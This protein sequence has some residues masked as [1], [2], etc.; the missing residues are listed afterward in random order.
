M[1]DILLINPPLVDYDE[2]N[3]PKVFVNTSF[4]PPINLAYLSSYLEK[5]NFSSVIVD[6]DAEKFGI[7]KIPN[8]LQKY[9]PRVIGIGITSDLIYP[10]S[11]KLIKKVK[12][13]VNTPIVVGG[14][15]PTNSP[16]SLI[17]KSEINYLIRGEGENTLHELMKYLIFNQGELELIN[18][19]SHK[20]NGSVINNPPREL[21]KDL[22]TIPFPSWE[23]FNIKKYFISISYKNPSF[24]ITASR[25]CP[26]R[27][28]FCSTSVFQYYRIRSPKNV[29]DEIE[30]LMKNF[31]IKD[32]TFH[33]PTFNT[34]QD[35]VISFCKEI[36]R[37]KVQLKW[38][39]LCR[40]DNIN[41]IM[42]AYMKAAGCYNIAFGIESSQDIFL[43]FLKKDFSIAQVKKA[44]KIVKKYKIEILTYFMYGIPGQKIED[45][46]HNIKFLK[47]ISP[48]Y[49]NILI[50]NPVSGTELH[51]YA[52][53]KGYLSNFNIETFNSPERLGIQKQWWSIPHLNEEILKH[54][55]IKSYIKY[56]VNIKT[57]LKHLKRYLK[58][59]TRLLYALKNSIIRFF[60]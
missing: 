5:H 15:F 45:L 21:I 52:L 54:F 13:M 44:I 35:W 36:L 8:I 20:T 47:D 29:V 28:T 32:I 59:P 49:I 48:D 60:K 26:Y 7:S 33:D 24:A 12:E 1:V 10:V 18:G 25:G 50:L 17:Q 37:R 6:M 4:F 14:V 30:Y 27:C 43:D 46:E 3:K 23:K 57:I 39:C 11:Y 42:I 55:I 41:D 40:V 34:N 31:N 2:K 56:F 22:D 53:S 16:E 19:L 9:K 58:T 51:E 38:R